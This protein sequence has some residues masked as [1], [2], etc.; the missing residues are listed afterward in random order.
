MKKEKIYSDKR[1]VLVVAL[2]C[3]ALWGSAFPCVKIGYELFEIGSGDIGAR[4]LFAGYRFSLAGLF[5]LAMQLIKKENIFNITKRD[6][7]EIA[8]LGL[9]QTTFQYIFFYIGLSYTTGVRGSIINGTG[10]FITIILAH[11]LYKNDKITF[12]KAIGCILGFSGIVLVSMKGANSLEGSFSLMGDGC[13]FISA[14]F[15]SISSLYSKKISQN[16][17]PFTMT[18]YQLLIGGILLIVLGNIYGGNL[19]NFTVKST[20]LLVYMAFLSSV[21]FALWSQLLKYNKVSS[22]TI[23]NFMIPVFGTVLSGIF[24][25]E[26]IFNLK[27]LIS[28]ILVSVGIFMVYKQSSSKE[29]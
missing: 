25:N 27:I 7:G 20:M 5:V 26:D 21:S 4:L 13:I 10:T 8:L 11:F 28:L 12:N 3:C 18:G 2:I 1:V 9:F 24:L 6:Y 19:T 16:K 17:D 15:S 14:L 22:V 23:F 29:Q